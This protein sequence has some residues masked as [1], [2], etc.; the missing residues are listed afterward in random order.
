[1]FHK[2]KLVEWAFRA[3]CEGRKRVE[4]RLYDE[5]RAKIEVKDTIEFE[6]TETNETVRCE[7]VSLTRF[8]DFFQA[9]AQYERSK[10]GFSDGTGSP[11]DMYA[12]YS[13]ELIEK[14]GVLA[15]GIRRS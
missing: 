5:K 4:L 1:M 7:V 15:I 8:K 10:L 9:F 12:F 6:N 11:E 2:M 13:P 14:Y 3:V